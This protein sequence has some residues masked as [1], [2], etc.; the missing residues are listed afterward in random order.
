[1]TIATE[2]RDMT[3]IKSLTSIGHT[4][5]AEKFVQETV[6]KTNLLTPLQRNT[7]ELRFFGRLQSNK[8]RKIVQYYEVVE[9]IASKRQ[10]LLLYKAWRNQSGTRM[11]SVQIQVNLGREPQK[12]G[13]LPEDAPQ[14][15]AYTQGL[16]LPLTGLMTIPPK[17]NEPAPHFKALRTLA[18]RHG[19]TEC[20][21]GFSDDYAIAI[22]CG[23]THIRVGRAILGPIPSVR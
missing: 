14:L 18:D 22:D 11:R 12:N 6:G 8:I 20:Q 2:K 17:R 23:A 5:F 7:I 21:M 10:A 13:C 19:L 16:G 1:M 15:I 4:R 3:Y 9:T